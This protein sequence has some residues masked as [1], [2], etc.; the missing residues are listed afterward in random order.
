MPD[1]GLSYLAEFSS[2]Y[3]TAAQ[4]NRSFLEKSSNTVSQLIQGKVSGDSALAAS[5]NG[6]ANAE[7]LRAVGNPVAFVT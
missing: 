2:G 1:S 3:T 5:L 4:H 6:A 7:T